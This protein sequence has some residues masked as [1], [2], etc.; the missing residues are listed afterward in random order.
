MLLPFEQKWD[1][2]TLAVVDEPS[3]ADKPSYN[4]GTP[5]VAAKLVVEVH[6]SLAQFPF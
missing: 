4:F 2:H 1:Q 6:C 3:L 5:K